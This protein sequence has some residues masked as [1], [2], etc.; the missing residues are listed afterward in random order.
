MRFPHAFALTVSSLILASPA[1][2][3]PTQ[4]KFVTILYETWADYWLSIFGPTNTWCR[5]PAPYDASCPVADQS[6]AEC[7]YTSFH[8][9]G[10]PALFNGD[11]NQYRFRKADGTA[12]NALI[13]NHASLLA[14]A[15][16]DF[17]TIDY[18]NSNLVDS[19]FNNATLTL[20]TRFRDRM[21]AGQATPKVAFFNSGSSHSTL[22]NTFYT[23]FPAS[24][25]FHVGGK[26]LL[27]SNDCTGATQFT[28]KPIAGLQNSTATWSFKERT[29]QPYYS[30]NGWPEE[31][32]VVP[33][34]QA[35]YI[36]S[37]LGNALGR[38]GGA[39]L[40][41]QWS[42][43]TGSNPTYVFVT[44]WNEW[45]SQ[46]VN[47]GN[48]S[49]PY[50]SLRPLLTDEWNPEFSS[51]FEPMYGGHDTFY[52]DQLKAKVAQYKR[53]APNF[54]LRSISSGNWLFK[55]YA[56]G[57]D[58]GGSNFTTTFP[59]AA[60]SQFQPITGDFDN[61]GYSDIAVRDV[62][63][64]VWHF[65]RRI[66]P[67]VYSHTVSFTW[68]AGAQFQP[69]V[70]DFDND[71]RT[72]IGLRDTTT[73]AWH[74][75]RQVGPYTYAHTN[76]FTW[77]AGGNYQP[78]IGDFDQN[79]RTDIG[80]RDTANG[81]WYLAHWVAPYTYSNALAFSWASGS[82]YQPITG[83]W[84]GDSR[85]DIGLRDS[86]T[87]NIVLLNNSGTFSFGNQETYRGPSGSDYQLLIAPNSPNGP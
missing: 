12:N 70:A 13:D 36:N 42:S 48:L 61:D 37:C 59:W 49:S 10:T 24:L 39:T 78:F 50:P 72:D 58:L 8:W 16:I 23:A 28:C 66:A 9:W 47:P 1:Y 44:G 34:T 67:Y 41:E 46:N 76:S 38:R 64:G 79:G 62:L 84:D 11:I 40:N 15:G 65:A 22:Y 3:A 87:G 75:A 32:S 27:M 18:S 19:R 77:A 29:P 68:A 21:A 4:N 54:V 52:Y 86:T 83:D 5:L 25:F 73:G 85:Q 57:N 45:G 35:D 74:F 63:N 7:P 6:V 51:D 31:I 71:G 33:A 20:L 17:I 82:N 56:G 26:P 30:S 80:L 14:A 69:L 81:V 55:Y 2:A 60:G 43:V 53:N